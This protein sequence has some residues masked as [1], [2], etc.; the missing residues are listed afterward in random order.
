MKITFLGTGGAFTKT[1][2]H[3]NLLL[4]FNDTNLIIDFGYLTAKSLSELKFHLANVQNLFITHLHADHIGGIEELAIIN[5]MIY[6]RKINLYIHKDL[7][8]P[9]WDSIKGG[10]MHNDEFEA[11]LNDYFNVVPVQK[12]FEINGNQF[13]LIKTNHVKN[14]LSFGLFFNNI[15]FT[16]DTKFDRTLL[17]E[18]GYRSNLI[19]HDCTF[20]SNPVHSYYKDLI[21]IP[22]T[23]K[24]KM[25]LIHYSDDYL[26]YFDFMRDLSFRFAEHHKTISIE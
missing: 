9:L 6:N 19:I 12:S 7:I 25:I 13:E 11:N 20:K 4:E 17:D 24:K 21:S 22:E 16:S 18:Y 1:L 15:L 23:L 2:F 26:K 10:L 14:M 3:S 8:N 5:R